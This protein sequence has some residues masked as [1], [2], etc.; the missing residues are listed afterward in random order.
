MKLPHAS[1]DDT[2]LFATSLLLYAACGFLIMAGTALVFA[3]FGV[4]F[5]WTY[6][7][8]EILKNYPGA[9]LTGLMPAIMACVA[10]GFGVVVMAFTFVRNLLAI[11]RTVGEGDPFVPLNADRLQRM[12]WLTLAIQIVGL[13]MGSSIFWISKR[14]HEADL[15]L[16]FGVESW[17]TILLLFVLARVFRRGTAMREELEGTV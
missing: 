3:L 16:D 6:A 14:L 11:I 10:L 17:I 8:A 13:I 12:A 15:S 4:S 1:S 5:G 7:S 9:N 2:L